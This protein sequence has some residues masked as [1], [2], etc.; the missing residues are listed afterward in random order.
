MQKHYLLGCLLFLLSSVT[1]F[2]LHAQEQKAYVYLFLEEKC[3]MCQYYSLDLR[4]M[5]D[6]YANQEV[7][8]VGL[9]PFA[10]SNKESRAEFAKKYQIPFPLQ[11]D[12]HQ[13][14]TRLYQVTVTPEVIVLDADGEIRYRG[15][16]DN[17]YDRPGRRRTLVTSHELKDA[18]NA[19]LLG[20]EVP[21]KETRAIGCY[22]T[23]TK[24]QP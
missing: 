22:I 16:I 2:Q 9:F 13:Q 21:V 24:S 11:A 5:Y 20:K 6:Q 12:E 18:L 3:P 8:F 19:I 7:S 23:L 1:G 15:R 14:L 4:E 17:A 10:G